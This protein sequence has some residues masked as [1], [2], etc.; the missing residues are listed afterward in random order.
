MMTRQFKSRRAPRNVAE[1][2]LVAE[3]FKC[4]RG[5]LFRIV[6]LA[7]IRTCA[8]HPASG[9]DSLRQYTVHVLSNDTIDLR[10]NSATY[11]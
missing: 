1:V 6:P 10:L 11:L 2:A 3:Q 9:K 5:Q 7:F 4:F 8:K